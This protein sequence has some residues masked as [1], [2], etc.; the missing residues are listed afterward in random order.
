MEKNNLV[1]LIEKYYLDGTVES[2]IWNIKDN[3]ATIKFT[4]QYKNL[5]GIITSDNFDLD[6]C[7]IGIYNTS[8]FL[9]FVRITDSYLELKLNRNTAQQAVELA[10]SD[11][12]YDLKYVLSNLDLIERVKTVNEPDAYDANFLIDNEFTDK[13]LKAKKALG[14]VNRFTVNAEYVQDEGMYIVFEI[15]DNAN[16]ANKIKFN[17]LGEAMLGLK[18]LAFPADL[19]NDI[20]KVN[21][22]NTGKIEISEHGILKASF[23][24]KDITATYYLVCLNES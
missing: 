12:Q 21:V 7:E 22:G 13:Y 17:V 15:G 8:Q 16:H 2:A 1:S 4:T 18:Q 10:I 24:E 9:K 3:K 11:N 6:D 19:F 23:K 14:D 5:V 20:L